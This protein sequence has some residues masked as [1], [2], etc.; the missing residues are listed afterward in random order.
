MSS[1]GLSGGFGALNAINTPAGFTAS[2]SSDATSAYLNYRLTLSQG[3]PL[4]ATQQRVVN[5][6]NAGNIIPIAAGS[7]TPAGLSQ[8]SGQS[9]PGHQQ[10]TLGAA[11]QFMTVMGDT[12][13]AGRGGAMGGGAIGYADEEL[14]YASGKSR[15]KSE[16]D[17]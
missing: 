10:V 15:S 5:A 6:L 13:I 16:R 1:A 14:S 9:M 7:L 4:N 2:L 11:T 12:S 8:I 3:G 17:A